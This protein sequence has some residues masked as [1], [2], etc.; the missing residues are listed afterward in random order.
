MLEFSGQPVYNRHGVIEYYRLYATKNNGV[1]VEFDLTKDELKTLIDRVEKTET[2]EESKEIIVRD[3]IK[4]ELK[5]NP[6][7]LDELRSL[8]DR[9]SVDTQYKEGDLVTYNGV[10]FKA[11]KTHI[12]DYDLIP[13]NSKDYWNE[14]VE[15]V[16]G[17]S[18]A[19]IEYEEKKKKAEFYSGDKTYNKGDLV[20]YY[21]KLY[22]SRE[23]KNTA[24]PEKSKTAWTLIPAPGKETKN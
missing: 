24:N 18:Q 11:L 9:W 4:E 22:E 2:V 12:S 20:V 10:L 17:K 5:Q 19:E 1:R 8:V 15:H 21:H 7:K 14:I 13:I 23:D 6:G 16:P 3:Y